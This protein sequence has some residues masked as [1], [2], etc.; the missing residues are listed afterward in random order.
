MKDPSMIKPEPIDV[1]SALKQ[2]IKEL[3]QSESDLKRAEERLRESQTE[4]RKEQEFNQLLLDT[5][6]ALM[7][8]IGFD[9]KT[10][11]MN[12]ALLDVLEYTKEEITGAD[13][14]NIVVPEEDRGTLAV[15]FQEIVKERKATV[16]ENRIRSKSGRTYLVEWHG[17]TVNTEGDSNFFVGVGIDVTERKQAEETLKESEEKY[18]S[19]FEN[20]VEGIFQVATDGHF[21]SAN[22]AMARIYGDASPEETIARITDVEQLYVDHRERKRYQDLLEK[23]GMVNN[24]ESQFYRKDGVVIW[25]SI[26]ARAVKDEAGKTLCYEGIVED[27]TLRKNAE[28]RLM[29]SE[30]RYRT[31]IEFSN[32]G[33]SLLRGGRHIYVN[34]RFLEIYGYDKPEEALGKG[35]DL[36]IHP[37]DRQM[38]VERNRR[39]ERGEHVTPKYEFKG[40]RKDGTTVYV[41]ISTARITFHGEPATLAYHRDITK[42]KVLEEKLQAI[43]ITD[44]LTGLYNRRGFFVLSQQQLKLARRTGKKSLLFFADLDKLKW[45]NDTIGHQEGDMALFETARVLKDTF[46]ETDVISRMGGDEFAVLAIDIN[47]ETAKILLGRLQTSL[48]AYN[49]ME[50]RKYKLSLSVGV[51]QYDPQ[52]PVSLD[53]LISHA[54]TLMYEEKRKKQ[55]RA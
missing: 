9:G 25:L 28:Q 37:D 23:Y 43:S 36:T 2:R 26:N 27:I 18:R 52:N 6:P 49:A 48:N 51:A 1:I 54:D 41:E 15:V 12:Q 31:A 29:E 53:V 3:E 10:L 39:R 38:V 4:F 22:P 32:D 35:L 16:N 46:R 45:I 19:I 14:M 24:F 34:R 33:V 7:V 11:M 21:I 55:G 47:D 8:A 5:S 13:Y 17:R 50:A 44:E 30:E 42:R 20:A 40:I